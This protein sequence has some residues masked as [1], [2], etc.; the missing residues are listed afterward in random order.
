MCIYIV[1]KKDSIAAREPEN[2]YCQS[3]YYWRTKVIMHGLDMRPLVLG[4]HL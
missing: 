4:H 1:V 3:N 2:P